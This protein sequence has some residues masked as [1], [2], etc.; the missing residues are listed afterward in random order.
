METRYTEALTRKVVI[1]MTRTDLDLVGD[2]LSPNTR[3]ELHR[4]ATEQAPGTYEVEMPE[5]RARDLASK[6]ANLGLM[7][8]R[9]QDPAGVGRAHGVAPPAV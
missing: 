5:T 2:P 8:A 3:Q 6:A 7:G 4:T 9:N 1:L